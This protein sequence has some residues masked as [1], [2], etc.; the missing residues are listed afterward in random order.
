MIITIDGPAAAG[1]GTVSKVL[2]EKYKLAYF[3]TGMIYRAVGL[4]VVL[5]GLNPENEEHALNVAKS[6]TFE[7][8]ME[9]SQNPDFRT[10]VGGLAASKVSAINSVR[11]IL[12]KMQQ[13]FALSP[14]FADGSKANGVI[15]DGRDT[16]TVVC[17]NADIKFFVTASTEVR[18][19]R[20][21]KEFESKGIKT[22]YEKVLEDMIARDKRDSERKSAPMKPA[23]DAIIMDTSNMDANAEIEAVLKIVEEKIEVA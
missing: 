20:R 2:S 13:D 22:T 6:M 3:D 16:G 10:D 15:Y 11:Q 18:A 1:K 4:E 23:V 9:L 14:V 12:L 7:K 5:R 17:P 8:M 19:M 21:F